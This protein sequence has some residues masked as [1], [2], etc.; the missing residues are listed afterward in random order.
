MTKLE[1]FLYACEKELFRYRGWLVSVF[2]VA[3]DNTDYFIEDNSEEALL[4]QSTDDVY[5]I[6]ARVVNR[7]YQVEI[8]DEW[9]DVEGFEFDLPLFHKDE[10]VTIPGMSLNGWIRN[11]LETTY[12]IW[13]INMMLSY[14]PYQGDVEYINGVIDKGFNKVAEK[15]LK[16]DIPDAVERHVR[17]ENMVGQITALAPI[18]VPAG[19]KKLL[20]P[21]PEIIA[22]RDKLFEEH[23][24]NLH[25]ATTVA[26]IQNI[27]TE[28]IKEDIKGDPSEDFIVK[29]EKQVATAMLRTQVM[30][31][32]E[33]DFY[34]ENKI[35]LM[36][37]SLYEGWQK[38]DVPMMTNISRGGSLARGLETALGGYEVKLTS[39]N[40]QNYTIESDDCGVTY[41]MFTTFDKTN[42]SRFVGRYLPNRN[43]PITLDEAKSFIGKEIELR[44]PFSCLGGMPTY[45]KKC[46]GDNVVNAEIGLNGQATML[47]SKFMD[48]FMQMMHTTAL[49]TEEYEVNLC[50]H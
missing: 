35:T 25:D 48:L 19:S 41:G 16:R 20:S 30:Y 33:P 1:Y 26:K 34:D 42:Y 6:K 8:D 32:S 39:R 11:D 36:K 37:G 3:L 12:G 7:V 24:D 5:A 4:S 10:R 43:E 49:S 14:Y 27:L 21:N 9:V 46:F 15:Q 31:G 29:A 23:K 40:F 17:F 47:T 44:S 45:C 28:A 2:G 18:A 50:I 13:I 38:E 22:L